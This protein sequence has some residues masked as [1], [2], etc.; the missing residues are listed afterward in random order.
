MS[1]Y[2]LRVVVCVAAV[3]VGV[4]VWLGA[5]VQRDSARE[6]AR[7]MDAVERM[8]TSVLDRESGARG[9]Q[10]TGSERFLDDQRREDRAFD[11]AVADLRARVGSNPA[12]QDDIDAVVAAETAWQNSVNT[13][14]GLWKREH[15]NQLQA[16]TKHS[17]NQLDD[18]RDQL[19]SLRTQLNADGQADERTAAITTVALALLAFTLVA[20]AGVLVMRRRMQIESARS[21]REQAFRDQ[22]A[23]FSRAVLS[24]ASEDEAHTLLKRYLEQD[25]RRTVTVL[26]ADAV[27]ERLE[28]RT[29][30]PDG[31]PLVARLDNAVPRDCVAVRLADAHEEDGD[32]LLRCDVCG[33]S[34]PNRLCAPL[35]VSSKVIGSV[36]T[37]NQARVQDGDRRRLEES[38]MI[39]APVLANLRTIAVAQSRASTDALTG[40]ANRRALDD[41]LE[42]MVAQSL[43]S[44]TPLAAIGIDLDH[45]KAINDELGHEAGDE[46]LEAVAAALRAGTRA[47]DFVGRWG[48]EEFC[49]LAP[50]TP[51]EGAVILAE[52]LRVAVARISLP[53]VKRNLSASFGVAVCPE[54]ATSPDLLLRQADQAL[55]AAKAGGRNRVELVAAPTPTP[56]PA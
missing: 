47:S 14:I 12:A 48:G 27:Q 3:I 17:E 46:V 11:A 1:K 41:T 21:A 25:G 5:E 53:G 37:V 34:G 35:V 56:T 9:Y 38:T 15:F 16:E 8:M 18:L 32:T 55:Y 20:I 33:Q 44:G 29:P 51:A 19:A 23:E 54:H 45:F 31:D 26:T 52:G 13:T 24:A 50:D 49:V 7:R 42:R 2:S 10:L 4:S 39:A 6:H 36:L 30:L 22:Q 43:R 28:A 40:L